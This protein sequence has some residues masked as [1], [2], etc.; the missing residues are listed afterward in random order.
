MMVAMR[1]RWAAFLA[2]FVF[3]LPLH[4]Q[5]IDFESNGLHFKTLTRNGL[6]IMFAPLSS[7]IRGYTVLQVA[8]SNGSPVSWTVKPED[9]LYLRQDN[10]ELKPLDPQA[11]V[12]SLMDKAGRGDVIKLLT[13]YEGGVYGNPNFKST[14]GYESRRQNALAFG[15]NRIQAAAAASAI[16]F[17][18]TRLNPGESTD[19]ALF[20]DNANKPLG[21]GKIQVHA[22][23][24]M[25]EYDI[26]SLLK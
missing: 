13:T 6:T 3:S 4:A 16:V 1:V 10:G 5:V 7:H 19:G 18:R 12:S 17:V 21:P 24:E 9:F 22:A 26:A 23:A 8:I 20:F 11:V 15:P 2:M 25:F 14:N